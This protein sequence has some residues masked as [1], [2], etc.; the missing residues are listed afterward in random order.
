M[1]GKR[2]EY[3][4]NEVGVKAN[5]VSTELLVAGWVVIAWNSSWNALAVV[6]CGAGVHFLLFCEFMR[7]RVAIYYWIVAGQEEERRG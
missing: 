5:S 3:A 1:G 6:A 7:G 4:F 2:V